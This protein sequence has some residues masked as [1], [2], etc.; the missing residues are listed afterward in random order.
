[1]AMPRPN[2]KH[3]KA[4]PK[5]FSP[6]PLILGHFA[7]KSTRASRRPPNKAASRPNRQKC[8]LLALSGHLFRTT[9]VRF[10]PKSGH[11]PLRHPLMPKSGLSLQLSLRQLA[12]LRALP[13]S[14]SD[15]L[16]RAGT[17]VANRKD[18]LSTGFQ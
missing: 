7:A 1:M 3:W 8:L 2:V 9:N 14:S 6:N 18:T 10:T 5:R 12:N 4:A 13:D 17:N 15:A 16:H 11:L